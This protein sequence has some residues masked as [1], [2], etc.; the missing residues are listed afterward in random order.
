M[1]F[2]SLISKITIIMTMIYLVISLNNE[3]FGIHL[4]T[5]SKFNLMFK[6]CNYFEFE[7]LKVKV[8]LINIMIALIIIFFCV[9]YQ[10]SNWT[11]LFKQSVFDQYECV[12]AIHCVKRTDIASKIDWIDV[13]LS[14]S[15]SKIIFNII[16]D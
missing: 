10:L 6:K 2:E 9:L 15:R 5:P 1:Q 14:I 8:I 13:C 7:S 12:Y 11:L 16:D 4:K 3:Y